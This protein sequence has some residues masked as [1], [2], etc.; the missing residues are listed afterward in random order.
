[1]KL[2]FDGRGLNDAEDEHKPRVVQLYGK[3][4][5]TE[6]YETIAA[7]VNACHGLDL[8]AD[9][10]PGALR[11]LVDYARRV[12]NRWDKG[13]LAEAVS[14]LAATLD[15][16]APVSPQPEAPAPPAPRNLHFTSSGYTVIRT[17]AGSRYEFAGTSREDLE[18]HVADHRERIARETRF[19]EA[20]QSYLD[21]NTEQSPEALR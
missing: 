8:P 17:P 11:L 18:K 9:I 21:G 7:A 15:E 12:V 13:N 19:M 14:G 2:T 16:I 20:L 4:D 3:F 6:H 10:T 1:M 5:H